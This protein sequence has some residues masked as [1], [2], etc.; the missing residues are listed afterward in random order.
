MN[1]QAKKQQDKLT[2]RY[3]LLDAGAPADPD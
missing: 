2:K 3:D 1:Q